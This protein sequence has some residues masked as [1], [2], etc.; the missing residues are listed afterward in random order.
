MRLTTAKQFTLAFSAVIA[1]M[2][3]STL[4]MRAY[5]TQVREASDKTSS[6][7]IP[8]ALAAA[9][10]RF[11]AVNVQQFLT[12][13]SATG[14]LDGLKDTDDSAD[15]FRKN[16]DAA[17]Q[18]LSRNH[19]SSGLAELDR[20][21]KSF[22]D[23]LELGKR[24]AQTYVSKGQEA[25]NILME[26]FDKATEDLSQRLDSLS[27]THA[28]EATK[29]IRGLNDMLVSGLAIQW[30][31]L[32]LSA[33]VSVVM[34]WL[35]IR[36][37]HRQL[38]AEPADLEATARRIASGEY[39]HPSD[40]ANSRGTG[41]AAALCTMADRLG[42]AV[43]T[44]QQQEKDAHERSMEATRALRDRESRQE[45][46]QVV[47]DSMLAAAQQAKGVGARI[48]GSIR[49]LSGNMS[50]VTDNMGTLN[51]LMVSTRTAME[52]MNEA[53]LEIARNTGNAAQSA[54]QSKGQAL[55]GA[56]GVRD[57]V[58]ATEQVKNRVLGLK[59]T[60]A[61]LGSQADSIGQV[62]GVIT[63]IADQT[64]LLAL[65][66]AIE[67]ARAGDAGRGFA[68]VADEVRKLA[69]KTMTATRQVSE[70]VQSIQARARENVVAVESAASDIVV[71]SQLAEE[72]GK[73]MQAIVGI[74]QTT[75]MEVSSIAAASEQQSATSE[76]I[77]HA[78][79]EVNDATERTR[80]SVGQSQRIVV[81]ISSLAEELDTLIQNMASGKLALVRTTNK[82]VEWSPSF[83][84]GIKSIDEQH[85]IL[86]DL[87]N[88]V[89]DAMRQHKPAHVMLDVVGRLKEYTVKHFREEEDL[90]SRHGFPETHEHKEQHRAFEK[91]VAEFEA[92]LKGGIPTVGM[93]V[94]R[95]LKDWLVKHIQGADTRY[96]SFLVE[97]GIR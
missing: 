18:I 15:T 49:D 10:M 42:E 26:D 30:A 5:L 89:H 4:I 95:Y 75:A 85:K 25:G 34:G 50:A 79:E 86:I 3:L 35:Y 58:A 2:L 1:L 48:F 33:L 40:C 45:E 78:V 43:A 65:N 17:R 38:G 37:L 91:K 83:S 74:V 31:L 90:F 22:A 92:N 72:S 51:N 8:L 60:M 71:S 21:E 14:H 66:A 96:A 19:D 76:E 41:V 56:Q 32:A 63:D 81:E 61:V 20:L 97:R 12:D 44:V 87:I 46:V 68:V 73:S 16:L 55:A 62:I 29:R 59:E 27:D 84:I 28:T 7:S 11:Q 93:D 13:V 64:N 54:E 52:Q 57:A 82:L 9:E 39:A 47:L 6:D 80:E 70:S 88:E 69:E 53:T 67:A 94:V 23:M 77:I 36:A 24:M